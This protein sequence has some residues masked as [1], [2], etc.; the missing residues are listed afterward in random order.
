LPSLG[1]WLIYHPSK[2]ICAAAFYYPPSLILH[3]SA[4]RLSAR[5]AVTPA[6]QKNFQPIPLEPER[7]E[8][9]AAAFA[10]NSL[11]LH[12]DSLPIPV[13][14]YAMSRSFPLSA[15]LARAIL[16]LHVYLVAPPDKIVDA[17]T[18]AAINGSPEPNL[19]PAQVK[20]VGCAHEHPL[21]K[22][23]RNLP[24]PDR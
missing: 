1:R 2:T 18:A 19:S 16:K 9:S 13:H 3:V 4:E 15:A 23:L 6:N 22:G 20:A 8:N 11:F 7:Q 24:S 5:C 17:P 14:L 21:P 12:P 10:I